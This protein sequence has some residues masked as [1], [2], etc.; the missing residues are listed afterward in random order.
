MRAVQ[1]AALSRHITQRD[2]S[3]IAVENLTNFGSEYY[4]VGRWDL[5]ASI[6]QFFSGDLH[7]SEG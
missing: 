2:A 3:V 6:E 7:L 1:A 4:R 5:T